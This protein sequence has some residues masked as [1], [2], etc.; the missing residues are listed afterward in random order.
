MYWFIKCLNSSIDSQLFVLAYVIESNWYLHK[1]RCWLRLVFLC[2][3]LSLQHPIRTHKFSF[4][5]IIER[6]LE[7]N[8]FLVTLMIARD[9]FGTWNRVVVVEHN[10]TLPSL[11]FKDSHLRW[12]S[13]HLNNR[14][15]SLIALNWSSDSPKLILLKPKDLLGYCVNIV[16][17]QL[18]T[19]SEGERQTMQ[20]LKFNFSME[21]KNSL[22][23][24]YFSFLSAS[25]LCHF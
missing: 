22:Q 2:A 25:R 11:V 15:L 10:S 7:L 24:L 9:V 5:S 8:D 6:E 19:I 14:K 20:Q 18:H 23:R 17:F 4:K 16:I 21:D 13:Q 1:D 12:H 3:P